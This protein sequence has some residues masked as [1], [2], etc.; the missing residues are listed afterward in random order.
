MLDMPAK[1]VG[2]VFPER[3]VRVGLPVVAICRVGA[4]G[5]GSGTSQLALG[6]VIQNVCDSERLRFRLQKPE[7]CVFFL[8]TA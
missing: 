4:E 7:Q 5:L 6:V 8:A 3:V 2:R 1:V